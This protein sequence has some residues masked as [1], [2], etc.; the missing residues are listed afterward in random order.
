MTYYRSGPPD[1]PSP[2]KKAEAPR[3]RRLWPGRLLDWAIIT[4]AVLL[5]VYGLSLNSKT[6]V[7]ASS[8][9]YRPQ[10]V[11][12]QAASQIT[13]GLKYRSKLTFDEKALSD[14]LRRQFPEINSVSANL[15]LFSRNPKLSIAV[16]EPSLIFQGTEGTYGVNL[17]MVIDAKGT[18]IGPVADFT[19]IK[20]LP[21]VYD[22][23]GFG[24]RKGEAALS[25]SDVNFILTVIA[26]AKKNKVPIKSLTFPKSAQELD[27]RTADKP[28]YVKFYLGGDPLLQ[29]GQLLAARHQFEQSDKQPKQYL[30]VR[31]AG[32]IFYK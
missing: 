25:R 21:L 16:A 27:L 10:A 20:N 3:K 15:S 1:A 24:A 12:E 19:S 14:S 22:E 5:A 7:E 13:S 31:V 18:V 17:K 2:F 6:E 28:Y 29:S 30:D 26:Q 9:A 8:E 32:K 11:Y 23:T 4:A